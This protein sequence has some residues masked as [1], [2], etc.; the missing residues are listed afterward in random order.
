MEMSTDQKGAVAE[1]AIE[2]AAVRLGVPVFRP[3]AEH[4]RYDRVLEIAGRLHRVQI[5]YATERDGVIRVN[6]ECSYLSPRG[7]VRCTYTP[8]EIDL[9]AV[10][11]P[12][13]DQSYL[14]PVDEVAGRRALSLRVAPTKNNQRA[15][16]NWAADY[17]FD[18]AIA[19]LEERLNGI[20]EAVGS[21]PTS[22]TSPAPPTLIGSQDFQKHYGYWAEQVVAGREVLVTKRGRP[23]LRLAA[24]Q[25]KLM[26][27]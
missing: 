17:E 6:F 3:V 20:Q 23:Y 8:E 27:A 19:Q 14:I 10:Y 18:G 2:L 4:Q 9:F 7:Y 21:S 1:C 15:S 5:K 25:P 11:C 16:L 22:S 12:E 26:A 24:A 13:V